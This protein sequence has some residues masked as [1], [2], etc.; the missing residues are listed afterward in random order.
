MPAIVRHPIFGI[1][2]VVQ[3][4]EEGNMALVVWSVER[5]SWVRHGWYDLKDEEFTVESEIKNDGRRI[6]SALRR[7]A[8]S[9]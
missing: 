8:A 1:G 5:R 7:K 2:E 6:L 3:R 9:Q 4:S